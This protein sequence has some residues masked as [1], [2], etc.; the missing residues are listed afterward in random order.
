MGKDTIHKTKAIIK[1]YGMKKR[2][3]GNKVSQ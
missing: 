1:I 3:T 2:A